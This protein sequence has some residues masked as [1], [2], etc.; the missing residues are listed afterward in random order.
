MVMSIL[1]IVVFNIIASFKNIRVFERRFCHF[2]DLQK[3]ELV[4]FARI[5]IGDMRKEPLIVF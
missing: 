5:S 1:Y 4:V 3:I 2:L